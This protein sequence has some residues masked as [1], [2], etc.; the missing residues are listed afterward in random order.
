MK[1]AEPWWAAT[2][3]L[4]WILAEWAISDAPRKA[5][6]YGEPDAPR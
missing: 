2:G 4:L 3:A 6:P 5:Q 1:A